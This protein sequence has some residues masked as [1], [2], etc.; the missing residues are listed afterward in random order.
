[1]DNLSQEYEIDGG[2]LRFSRIVCSGTKHA[3]VAW[4]RG[5]NST[6]W[7]RAPL[8]RLTRDYPD[9]SPVWQFLRANG[10]ARYENPLRK[11]FDES[12]RKKE[13]RSIYLTTEQWERVD[14]CRGEQSIGD[15]LWSL[16]T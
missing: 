6:T 1:M 5:P 10:I 2:R 9:T 11:K 15:Y 8:A 3:R 16:M 12:Q 7:R 13:R 4:L 14:A